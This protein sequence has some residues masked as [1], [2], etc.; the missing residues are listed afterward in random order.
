M[1]LTA[2]VEFDVPPAVDMDSQKRN[3]QE[4]LSEIPNFTSVRFTQNTK[5][6]VSESPRNSC[7]LY[8][9]NLPFHA[10]VN[11][12]RSIF[13]AYGDVVSVRIMKDKITKKSRG[14]AFVEMPTPEQAQSAMLSLNGSSF[15]QRP[16]K[17]TMAN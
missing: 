12:L 1:K 4:A 5:P 6:R 7:S 10:E 11:H 8:V 3:L 17:V 14:F 9:G 16:L 2:I 13:S 15:M